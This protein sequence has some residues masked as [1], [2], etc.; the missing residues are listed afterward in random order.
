MIIYD[1]FTFYNEF[2]LLE[3]RLRELSNLVDQFVIVE[4]TRTFQNQPKPLYFTEDINNPRWDPYQNKLI[5]VQVDDMPAEADAWARERRQR[6]AILTGVASARPDDIV[7]IGEVSH[8]FYLRWSFC[9]YGITST[10]GKP[11]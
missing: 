11:W 4:A 1:C 8:S 10:I 9:M 6:N 7:M 3:L 2:D 5:V